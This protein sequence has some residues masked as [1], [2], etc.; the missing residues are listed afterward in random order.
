M[1][2]PIIKLRN[3]AF[4]TSVFAENRQDNNGREYVSYSVCLQKAYKDKQDQWQNQQINLFDNNV[5]DV[6]LL[7]Q[8][9]YMALMKLRNPAGKSAAKP[10][11]A[12]QP[13]AQ[14]APAAD[15]EAIDDDVPF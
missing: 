14:E 15:V 5:A 12:A 9:T 6:A 3:G 8:S 1:A 4:S 10:A 11:A 13:A 7:L 2:E